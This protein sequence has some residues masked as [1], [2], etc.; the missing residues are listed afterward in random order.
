[1]VRP[2]RFAADQVIKGGRTDAAAKA[3]AS[4]TGSLTGSDAVLD[5]AFKRA[6]VL[7]VDSMSESWVNICC[8]VDALLFR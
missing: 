4:H 6:G 7:R 1:M 5:A 8:N 2:V 3:A